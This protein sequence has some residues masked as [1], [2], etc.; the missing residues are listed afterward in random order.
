MCND[1]KLAKDL[2]NLK[3]FETV[4][5]VAGRGREKATEERLKEKISFEMRVE[6]L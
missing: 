6:D 3:F 2:R 4:R 1:D 5:S